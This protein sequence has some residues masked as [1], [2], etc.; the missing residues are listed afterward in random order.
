MRDG[1]LRPCGPRRHGPPILIGSQLGPRMLRLVA[2]YADLWNTFLS[3]PPEEV[4]TMLKPLDAACAAIGRDPA[5]LGRALLLSVD[6]PGPR[7]HPPSTAYGINRA[8]EIAAGTVLS[9]EPAVIAARLRAYAEAGI[10]HIIV[11]LDPDTVEGIKSFA[12]V[13]ALL[14]GD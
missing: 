9:G 5:T 12:P 7:Q 4:E 13:L 11:Q 1:E 6:L 14:D 8:D 2:Q 3:M 10:G